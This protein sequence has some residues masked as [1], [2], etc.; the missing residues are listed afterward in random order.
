[1]CNG[2]SCAFMMQRHHQVGILHH[3]GSLRPPT[4]A[5]RRIT[6]HLTAPLLPRLT[7]DSH[8]TVLSRSTANPVRML[9]SPI[10]AA[11]HLCPELPSRRQGHSPRYLA[12]L[13]LQETEY[14]AST[15]DSCR[16]CLA[17]SSKASLHFHLITSRHKSIVFKQAAPTQ[18]ASCCRCL[19]H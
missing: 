2:R 17:A 13:L 15:S 11:S 1:M 12:E 6:L 3:T 18:K 14:R 5:T 7:R 19:L 10:I 4:V 9:L 8:S 16:R